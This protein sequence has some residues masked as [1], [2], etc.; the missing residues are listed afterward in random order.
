M[1]EGV[2]R[3]AV[4]TGMERNLV[5]AGMR[6]L[7][8]RGRRSSK[9]ERVRRPVGGRKHPSGCQPKL[10]GAREALVVLTMPRTRSHRLAHLGNCRYRKS[11]GVY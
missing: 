1:R 2:F 5:K 8:G 9:P 7:S 4:A 6:D 3:V 10:L 11:P